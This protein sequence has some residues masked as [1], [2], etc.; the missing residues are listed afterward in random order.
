MPERRIRLDGAAARLQAAVGGDDAR[1]LRGEADRLA[2]LRLRRAVVDF[3]VVLPERRRQRP[4]H[5]HAVRCRQLLHQPEDRFRHR[6]RG[7][8][9]RLQVAELGAVG[10]PA[11]PEQV[12]HLL[13]RRPFREVVDVVAVVRKN[14]AI[15]IQVTD[16]G[17]RGDY[18]FQA[19]FGLR[20]FYSHVAIIVDLEMWK[21]RNVEI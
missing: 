13:E 15:A 3:G 21:F 20:F 8:E 12:A 19:G 18:V 1:H 2:V 5:V 11:V 7:G 9:L 17:G 4:Q 10:Q 16:G 14:A 6:T